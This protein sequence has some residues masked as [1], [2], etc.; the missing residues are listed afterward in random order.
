VSGRSCTWLIS[1]SL[2]CGWLQFARWTDA[3]VSPLS[4]KLSALRPLSSMDVSQTL[5]YDTTGIR[6]PVLFTHRSS[7]GEVSGSFAS[8]FFPSQVSL[9]LGEQPG[10][11]GESPGGYQGSL[12]FSRPSAL[13]A[14]RL[15]RPGQSHPRSLPGSGFSVPLYGPK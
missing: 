8:W 3:I 11:R 5:V 12:I 6:H 10:L 15:E 4:I 2:V 14:R 9:H 1:V 7:L 13:F